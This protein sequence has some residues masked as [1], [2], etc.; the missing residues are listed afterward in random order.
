MATAVTKLYIFV[1]CLWLAVTNVGVRAFEPRRSIL[2]NH[3]HPPNNNLRIS[4]PNLEG[5]STIQHSIATTAVNPA[6]NETT[7]TMKKSVL[8]FLHKECRRLAD[9]KISQQMGKY[10][11]YIYPL[12]GIKSPQLRS[13]IKAVE[14][15]H[16][17]PSWRELLETAEAL[18]AQTHGEKKL[19][20]VYLLGT[21]ANLRILQP[22]ALEAVRTV[23]ALIEDHVRDWA[24]CDGFS[25]QV[26]R[27][28]VAK[29]HQREQTRRRRQ[30]PEHAGEEDDASASL[31]AEVRSWSDSSND[32]KQ[33]ASC[34]S[35]VGLARHGDHD[36]VILD[37]A[38]RVLRNPSRFP[39]LGAGWV[40]RELS[41]ADE[42]T[43]VDFIK[44]HYRDFSREGLR[45]AI[46]KMDP[47]LRQELLRFEPSSLS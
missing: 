19:L 1:G 5:K 15:K 4:D 47:P 45:Y 22:H 30:R 34:V 27:K 24:S 6:A 33:R 41:R 42:P 25:M 40:I 10:H 43:V 23:G 39:Q 36:A 29:A 13:L 9:P 11:K 26:V 46:E 35:F 31:V 14:T 38:E 2:H 20:A 21:N 17:N 12:Y 8:K 16:P 44:V 37:I 32:W 18:V 3:H 7:T 28:L